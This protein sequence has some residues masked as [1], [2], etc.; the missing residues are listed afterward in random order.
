[1]VTKKK[2]ASDKIMPMETKSRS[3]GEL[4]CMKK[5]VDQGTK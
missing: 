2:L 3:R 1:M 4:V 5:N